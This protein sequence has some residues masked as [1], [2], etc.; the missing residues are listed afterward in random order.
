VSVATMLLAQ[1]LI[2]KDE[3][4]DADEIA[5]RLG[6]DP[7][8]TEAGGADAD[9]F[10]QARATSRREVGVVS[11]GDS[12]RLNEI[13]DRLQEV[14]AS[15][16]TSSSERAV[17]T[18]QLRAEPLSVQA[19]RAAVLGAGAGI[20]TEELDVAVQLTSEVVA[21]AIRSSDADEPSPLRLYVSVSRQVVRVKLSA[22]PP[23]GDVRSLPESEW[24]QRF[25]AR[26]ASR[27]GA[28]LEGDS[29]VRWFDVDLPQPGASSDGSEARAR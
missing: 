22:R 27:W 29:Y 15:S 2:D 7:W 12:G 18:K 28:G 26:L 24:G 1:E 23:D 9:F 14:V 25:V 20:P 5:A 19:A 17:L 4:A 10:D 16:S 11:A 3:A 8:N 21:D 6:V 13:V